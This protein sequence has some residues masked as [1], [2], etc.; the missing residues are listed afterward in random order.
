M[1]IFNIFVFVYILESF[2]LTGYS[3]PE[4][5]DERCDYERRRS[6]GFRLEDFDMCTKDR[7]RF[8]KGEMGDLGKESSEQHEDFNERKNDV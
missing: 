6:E 7:K 8:E 3:D 2:E 1:Y 4:N 5:L